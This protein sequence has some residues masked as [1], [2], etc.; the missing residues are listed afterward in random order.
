[1]SRARVVPLVS[2]L[3]VLVALA[4]CDFFSAPTAD[5]VARLKAMPE[6]TM[7]YPGSAKLSEGSAQ[8]NDPWAQADYGRTLG[9]E[10]TLQQV[11]DYF[12][13]SLASSGWT[14]TYCIHATVIEIT[15]YRWTKSDAELR[16]GFWDPKDE[17][18]MLHD[19]PS[20]YAT[21]YDVDLLAAMTG[22]SPTP[23]RPE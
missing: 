15:C 9:T 1:M 2:V 16:L 11:H 23:S 21:I 18:H 20:H 12:A 13:S 6:A 22:W 5:K 8:E 7:A 3:A 4:G 19:W 14:S 10:A 17:D